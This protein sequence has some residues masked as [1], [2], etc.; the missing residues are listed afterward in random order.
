MKKWIIIT[1]IMLFVLVSV[2]VFWWQ[3]WRDWQVREGLSRSQ[4]E[5]LQSALESNKIELVDA[6]TLFEDFK[7]ES[8]LQLRAA[9]LRFEE[10]EADLSVAKNELLLSTTQ[11]ENQKVLYEKRLI[12][13]WRAGYDLGHEDALKG[14]IVMHDPTQ[15]ELTKFLAEN[16]VNYRAWIPSKYVCVDFA[17]DLSNDAEAAGL[18]SAYVWAVERY[19]YDG[20]KIGHLLNGFQTSD[21][22]MVFIEPQTDGE[23]DIKV[24][25]SYYPYINGAIKEIIIVW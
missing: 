15:E 4:I 8:A 3:N 18:R 12:D 25:G 22:G 19:N 21:R 2:N 6:Q 5:S 10:I 20:S 23:V 17:A 7:Q 13:D 11:I 9:Q 14:K 16:Q 1:L 24:G